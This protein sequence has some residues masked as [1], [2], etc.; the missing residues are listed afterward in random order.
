MS[1]EFSQMLFVCQLIYDHVVFSFFIQWIYIS[2][3]NLFWFIR[4][5]GVCC[6]VF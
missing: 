6:L 3:E 4:Y 1:V 2:L 5:L